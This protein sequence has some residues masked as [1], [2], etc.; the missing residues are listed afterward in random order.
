[1]GARGSRR[2]RVVAAAM[3]VSVLSIA[4]GGT[5]APWLLVAVAATPPVAPDAPW[6]RRFQATDGAIVAMYEPQVASWID[7]KTMTLHA[8]VSY[9][10]KA[11]ATA[12]I[13][14]VVVEAATRVSV[15]ERL[16]DFSNFQVVQSHFP[17]ASKD[18]VAAAVAAL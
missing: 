1:M 15:S 5:F 14:T 13:G 4:P 18:Q 11:A 8:A 10:P 7:Q 3:A 17:T 9:L 2:R 6:P 16:V 12:V